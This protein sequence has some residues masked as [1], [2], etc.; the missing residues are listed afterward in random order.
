MLQQTPEGQ[1]HEKLSAN[2]FDVTTQ[3]IPIAIRTRMLK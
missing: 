2:K 1:G 3:G